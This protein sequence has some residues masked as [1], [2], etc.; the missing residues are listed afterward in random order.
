MGLRR[1]GTGAAFRG[2]GRRPWGLLRLRAT[3]CDVAFTLQAGIGL[4]FFVSERTAITAGYRF[5][6]LS[7]GNVC[8]G[9]PG[10][11]SSL[12]VL[13]VSRFFP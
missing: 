2:G 8:S 7:N 5:H 4:L 9:N 12:F 3:G 1:H 11:D 6:H 13:G 10:L